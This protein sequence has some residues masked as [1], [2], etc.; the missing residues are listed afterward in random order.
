MSV[1]GEARSAFDEGNVPLSLLL[2]LV[3]ASRRG[4]ALVRTAAA[5]S[6]TQRA[7]KPENPDH[8]LVLLCL[9]IV[10]FERK[11]ADAVVQLSD[12]KSAMGHAPG[13]GQARRLSL[14]ELRR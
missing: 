13:A 10:A 14:R 2:G 5:D 12:G 7:E 9:G 8:P 3:S 1:L 6:E 11:L 4:G